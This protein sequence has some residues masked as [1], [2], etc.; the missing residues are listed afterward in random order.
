MFDRSMGFSAGERHLAAVGSVK[1]RV[2]E[3]ST[4]VEFDKVVD[5]LKKSG[6]D[7][8]ARTAPWDG[9]WRLAAR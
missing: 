9:E 6:R 7:P 3:K 5:G 1:L 2:L 8:M 4:R